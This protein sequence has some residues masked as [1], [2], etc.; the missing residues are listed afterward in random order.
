MINGKIK[1]AIFEHAKSVYPHECAG[2]VTQKGRVQKYHRID[3]V[4][5]KPEEHCEPDPEQYG[6][7]MDEHEGAI[8]AFVHSHTGDGAT[9]LPSAHD[10]CMCN[11]FE[12]P[13]VIVSLPEGD[14]RIVE[15]K[16]IPLIGRP[17][18]LGSYDCWGLIMS[19]HA[20]H[21]IKLTDYRKPYEWWKEGENL[22]HDLWGQEG[23]IVNDGAPRFG[24][25]VIM[26]IQCNVWNHAGIYVGDN[27]I[28]HHTQ[29]RLSRTDIFSGW[30]ESKKTLICRHKD[31]D[32]AISQDY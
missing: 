5:A 1:M 7:V 4:S 25:M 17:W 28:L 30:Y 10:T 26:Q 23:F 16:H 12:I 20:L 31:L 19:F 32:Y 29:D 2:L 15:P 24:D 14:M 21:G 3:N 13:F 9:T 11:E 6:K 18:S 27:K 8:V 22:Y